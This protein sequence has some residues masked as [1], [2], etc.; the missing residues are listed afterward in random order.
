M[1]ILSKEILRVFKN[2][3]SYLRVKYEVCVIK[4]MCG[5]WNCTIAVSFKR[6]LNTEK[7]Q[8]YLL[9]QGK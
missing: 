3:K 8:G 9:P 7:Q 4:M 2:L 5:V 6:T 1:K